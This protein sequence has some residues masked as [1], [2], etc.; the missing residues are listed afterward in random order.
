MRR[1]VS[2]IGILAMSVSLVAARPAAAVDQWTAGD[3]GWVQTFGASSSTGSSYGYGAFS[4]Y[5]NLIC[6]SD[7]VH[8]VNSGTAASY[9]VEFGRTYTKVNNPPNLTISLTLSVD[10]ATSA[11]GGFFSSGDGYADGTS[12]TQ[13]L[14]TG[15]AYAVSIASSSGAWFYDSDWGTATAS[16]TKAGTY[17]AKSRL[18]GNTSG[19]SAGPNGE[20]HGDT[21]YSVVTYSNP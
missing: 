7:T 19:H 11:V 12:Q 5:A 8:G 10:V 9:D 15:V 2:L 16:D 14:G 20:G 3:V 1:L 4:Y 6:T 13:N 21:S 17:E 18:K